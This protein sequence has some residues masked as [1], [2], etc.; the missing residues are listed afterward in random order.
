MSE[1]MNSVIVELQKVLDSR[2]VL[3]GEEVVARQATWAGGSCEAAAIVCP[4]TTDEVSAVMRI[5]H[6]TGQPV[7]AQGGQTSVVGGS[8]AKPNEIVLSLERM[9]GIEELD[10]ANRSMIVQAGIPLQTVQE[11]A[12]TSGLMFAIDF[13]VRGSATIGG[14]IATN[15]GGN[16]VIRYGM[17]REQILGIEA[18]LAD[19]TIVSSLGKA[20]KNNAGYDIK[21]LFIGS[22]GTL[23]I[24]TRAVLRLRPLM[25]TRNTALAAVSNFNSL[26]RL[27]KTMDHSLGGN[28]SAFEV[29]WNSF[30]RIVSPA[31]GKTQVPLGWEHPYYV[32]IE[33][34]GSEQESDAA[35]FEQVLT[36]ALT[37]ELVLDAVVAKSRAE[38]DDLW[39]IR[40]NVEA[41]PSLQ[42]LFAFDVSLAIGEMESYV[43]EV[44]G[45]ITAQWPNCRF[46][47]M[48]HLGDGNIHIFISVGSD[49]PSERSKVEEMVYSSLQSRKGSISAEHGIGQEKLK[50]LHY[51]RTAAELSL[52]GTLKQTLDPQGILN[53]GKVILP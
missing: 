4:R 21:Q 20:I 34:T 11:E 35:H 24:I 15:A 27:L 32:L 37:N 10:E 1:P 36:D 7:V 47:V 53:P 19:G 22:E 30:Y 5:C 2:G 48:G 50:H 12:E 51:S 43:E 38:R 31:P 49:E 23:G 3:L 46:L 33:A 41:L 44:R 40:E 42:P 39:A 45:K 9:A 26:V 6:Q 8:L 52:M 28:L 13:T 17:T 29:M 14:I 18:V 25:H 16:R